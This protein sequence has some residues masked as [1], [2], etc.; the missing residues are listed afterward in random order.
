MEEYDK[1]CNTH[2][3]IKIP[4]WKSHNYSKVVGDCLYDFCKNVVIQREG[5][6]NTEKQFIRP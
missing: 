5:I 4:Q 2:L 6:H 3:R 1:Y